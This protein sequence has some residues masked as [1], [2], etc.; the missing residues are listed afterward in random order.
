IYHW[1]TLSNRLYHRA[2][3][4]L[5]LGVAVAFTRWIAKKQAASVAFWK[6]STGWL[7]V[8][9]LMSFV[10]IQISKWAHERIAVAKL[11]ASAQSTPNILVIVL[12]T[13]RA[14]HLS[15]YGYSRTTSPEID[16]IAKHGVLFEHAIAPCS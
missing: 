7:A 6:R 2:C 5:A 12:D 1:L 8:I 14:D 10:T 16:R 11:P 4:I 15:S 9:F 3:L 13:L